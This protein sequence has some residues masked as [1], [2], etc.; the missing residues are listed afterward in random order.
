[1]RQDR[2]AVEALPVSNEPDLEPKAN[3]D[4]DLLILLKKVDLHLHPTEL[5]HLLDYPVLNEHEQL[6]FE[7]F[8]V[9]IADRLQP[10]HAKFLQK[11][12][13]LHTR[14]VD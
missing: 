6:Q 8:P 13:E 7:V 14:H 5:L 12:R 4:Q 10:F 9:T 3:R 2:S 1:M 11:H